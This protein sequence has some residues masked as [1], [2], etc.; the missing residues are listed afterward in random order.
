MGLFVIILY[1]AMEN[2]LGMDV[3]IFI[4]HFLPG[5]TITQGGKK[6]Y[7]FLGFNYHNFLSY[8][9]FLKKLS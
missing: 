2:R 1:V 7:S 6:K 3:R 4:L 5:F 8:I 9:I